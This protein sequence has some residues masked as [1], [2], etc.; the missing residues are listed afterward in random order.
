MVPGIQE[1]KRMRRLAGF[2]GDEVRS[3]LITTIRSTAAANI[4]CSTVSIFSE[5]EAARSRLVDVTPR[6]VRTASAPAKAAVRVARSAREVT[7]A[8]REPGGIIVMRSGRERTMAV[9]PI[10]SPRHTLRMP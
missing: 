6:A 8:T 3:E 4:A 5:S 9:K 7:T 1:K 10:P 2:P